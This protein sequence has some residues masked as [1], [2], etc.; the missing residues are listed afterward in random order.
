MPRLSSAFM[1][2][3]VTMSAI[4]LAT[5]LSAIAA[6]ITITADLSEAPRKLWHADIVIPVQPGEVTLTAAKWIPG[7]H[8]PTGPIENLTG[9]VFRAN[10]QTLTWRRD[11][12]DLYA[13]HVTVP[14]GVSTLEVHVD[15]IVTARLSDKLAM[16]EREKLLLYPAGIPV[17]EIQIQPSIKVPAGWGVGTA[18]TPT[19]TEGSTT[20]FAPVNS[21][22]ARRL[23]H[24]DRQ[25]L[26]GNSAGAGCNAEAFS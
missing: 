24:P 12:V 6:P 19:G 9:V 21:R 5:S 26:Q 10:G 8:R 4:L 14:A 16:L 1:R 2:R 23:A 11:D 22:D 13:F 18:L 3:A 15:A 25:V 17:R 20:H 7:N